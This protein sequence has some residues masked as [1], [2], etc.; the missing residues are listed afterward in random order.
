MSLWV[1]VFAVVAGANVGYATAHVTGSF[2]VGVTAGVAVMAMLYALDE[3][4]HREEA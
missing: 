4:Y 3:I 2:D 1:V